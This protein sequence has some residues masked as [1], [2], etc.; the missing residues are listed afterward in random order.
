MHMTREMRYILS[1]YEHQSFSRAAES[2]YISQ[3]SLSAI[4]KKEEKRLG[5]LLFDRSTNPISLTPAGEYYIH[6]AQKIRDIETGIDNCFNDLNSLSTGHLSLGAGPFLCSF[7]LP[8]LIHEFN[9]KYPGISFEIHEAINHGMFERW[10]EKHSIDFALLV[11]P[12]EGTTSVPVLKEHLILAVNKDRSINRSL[13]D[14]Q[15]SYADIRSGKHRSPSC[16]CIN[17][18]SFEKEDFILRQTEK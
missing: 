12:C 10:F 14:C 17:L 7:F 2:L 13:E 5:Q 16:P 3:P 9:Q 8:N 18:K 15:L 6:A 1:V 4:V 11:N